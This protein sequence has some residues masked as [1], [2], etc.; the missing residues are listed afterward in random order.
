VGVGVTIPS[1]VTLTVF[2]L[3]FTV[4]AVIVVIPDFLAITNPLELM[5]ATL[6]SLDDQVTDQSVILVG[7]ILAL[8]CFLP[9]IFKFKSV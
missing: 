7:I 6:A 5:V 9:L 1:T 3:L 2:V 8:I 4:L